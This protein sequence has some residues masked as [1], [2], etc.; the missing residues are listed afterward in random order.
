M[1]LTGPTPESPPEPAGDALP[2]R[3]ALISVSDKTAVADFAAGL[4]KLGVEIISTGGTQAVLAPAR[5]WAIFWS[6]MA[7]MRSG[8]AHMPL[9]IWARPDSPHCSPMST[10]R[11]S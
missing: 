10:L 7:A 1:S 6:S 8:I 2:V 11:A 4:A 9:P 5:G 3:R